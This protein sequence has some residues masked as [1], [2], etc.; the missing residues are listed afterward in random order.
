MANSPAW[1][2]SL[3]HEAHHLIIDGQAACVTA[4]IDRWGS[5][6]L[7][8]PADMDT[9]KQ[10]TR[11]KHHAAQAVTP[12]SAF[13]R[14]TFFRELGSRGGK[15]G[16]KVSSPAKARAARIRERKRRTTKRLCAR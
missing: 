15:V 10:C 9:S 8:L 16:G 7:V 12:V 13:D 3:S 1:H 14:S 11:C 2:R 6:M 5:W 4:K